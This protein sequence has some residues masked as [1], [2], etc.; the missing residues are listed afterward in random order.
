MTHSFFKALLFLG[1]GSVIH[2][3]SG[4]QG[5][6]KMGG[7]RKKIP[8]T[9]YT[10]TIGVLAIIGFP[11][12]SGFVSKD[13]I[14]LSVLNH[15]KIYFILAS[16]GAIM[17]AYYMLRMYW[18]TFFGSFR[19]THEQEHHLHESPLNMTIPLIVLACLSLLGGLFQF[20]HIFGGHPYLNNYLSSI[21]KAVEEQ[22]ANAGM[23]ELIIL[24]VTVVALA[25]IYLVTK[26]KFTVA[27]YN[28]EF[29]GVEKILANKYYVDELY[30]NAFVNPIIKASKWLYNIIDQKIIEGIVFMTGKFVTWTGTTLR[31]MQ[32]GYTGSYIFLMV[33]AFLIIVGLNLM[34]LFHVWPF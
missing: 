23:K 7:L 14:L 33:C 4:E 3:M 2:A 1:A 24:G 18:L 12:T 16:L 15:N 13:E 25:I 30:D 19:G 21:V 31:Y 20:P 9:F 10:F 32:N 22:D 5:I 34:R 26:K 11:F 8:I 27:T 29:K 6:D 17:T 28:T